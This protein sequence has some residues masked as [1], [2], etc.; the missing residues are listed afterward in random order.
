MEVSATEYAA[1][2]ERDTILLGFPAD[3]LRDD[4]DFE[5]SFPEGFFL[6][7]DNRRFQPDEV[8]TLR[9][10]VLD[11]DCDGV[12]DGDD[13]FPEDPTESADSDSDGVGDNADAFPMTLTKQLIL[14]ETALAIMGTM[15]MTVME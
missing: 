8:L 10:C 3:Q 1:N 2:E 4:Q 11:Y 7:D 13:A 12:E 15:T 6:L 14:T 9:L 5:E